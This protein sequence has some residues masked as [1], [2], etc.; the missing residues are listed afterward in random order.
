MGGVP[1]VD[2]FN[3]YST[4]LTNSYKSYDDLPVLD[5]KDRQGNT[6]YIDFISTS[7][8]TASVMKFEDKFNR[9]GFALHLECSWGEHKGK[10]IVLA[11]FQRYTGPN[12]IWTYGWGNSNNFLNDVYVDHHNPDHTGKEIME[13]DTC[14]FQGSNITI[15]F[16]RKLFDG[17]DLVAMFVKH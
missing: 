3:E 8:M 9:K 17:E 11:I 7:E 12:S 4:L 14:P 2:M 1:S 16:L 15:D 10:T 13:C 5:L 6:D